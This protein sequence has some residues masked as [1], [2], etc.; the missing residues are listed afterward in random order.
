MQ[1]YSDIVTAMP[2][3][4]IEQISNHCSAFKEVLRLRALHYRRN[5]AGEQEDIDKHSLH[6]N[7]RN[8]KSILGA[9][10]VICRCHGILESER[11]Y[12]HSLGT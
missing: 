8:N 4:K 12:P 6:F 3:I 7:A 10:R 2:Q 1:I 11:F 5:R 9:V